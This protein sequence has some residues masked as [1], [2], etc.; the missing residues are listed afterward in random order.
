MYEGLSSR[1]PVQDSEEIARVAA[2]P[3]RPQVELGQFSANAKALV[4]IMNERLRR[5]DWQRTDCACAQIA[6]GRAANGRKP[7]ITSLLPA[8]AW[9]L[10]E[11]PLVGGLIGL[12]ATGSGKTS[13]GFLS[14]MVFPNCRLAVGI[15]PSNLVEQLVLEYRLWRE[16]WRVPRLVYP[17]KSGSKSELKDVYPD[18]GFRPTLHVVPYSILQQPTSTELLKSLNPDL[19]YADEMDKLA[20]LQSARTGR[21]SR[22]FKEH[23]QSRFAGWTGTP[24]DKS[25]ME[26]T[27][28]AAWALRRGSPLPVKESVA[29]EWALA[30]DPSD[31]KA[32][33]GAL[34]K[35]FRP[36]ETLYEGFHRRLVETHGVVAT[37]EGAVAIPHCIFEREPPPMPMVV[38][39]ALAKIRGWERPDEEQLVDAMEVM[40]VACE[41][42]LGFYYRWVF[43]HEPRK[44]DGTLTEAAITKIKVWRARRK[45]WRK[46]LRVKLLNRQAHLDSEKL[47]EDA[48]QRYHSGYEG[49][50]PVWAAETY[51]A[52]KEVEDTVYHET[53]A[54]WLDDWVARDAAAWAIEHRGI[55]W[56]KHDA[57]GQKVAEL[58]GLPLHAGGPDAE[59]RIRAEKGDRSIIASM[60][61][62]GRGRDGLQYLFAEQL[63][64]AFP[65]SGR[66]V[67]Q[68]F[69]RLHRP[70][71]PAP[72]VCTWVYQHAV[73]LREAFKQACARAR[74]ANSTWGTNQ[75]L[76]EA[77]CDWRDDGDEW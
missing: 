59:E 47:C 8:Q 28:L 54:V 6:P 25:I 33:P 10:F 40:R 41:A 23:P 34:E 66:A 17:S 56:Y 52:W 39:E 24:W 26:C 63:F 61:S 44:P 12:L 62:H 74:F 4:E 50:L 18:P 42:A 68:N 71:Q 16:H 37:R 21:V 36:G 30:L 15:V 13:I 73:E 46:E 3:R 5:P 60:Q 67:E 49:D 53:Q 27:H 35:L 19:I 57:F 20:N 9:A 32:E 38:A 31:S 45:A 2:L 29:R 72:Q 1:P 65:S 70:G 64:S 22:H 14:P 48:A 69:A 77:N 7:C 55:V 11:A 75:K 76:L 51:L 43:P 58:S